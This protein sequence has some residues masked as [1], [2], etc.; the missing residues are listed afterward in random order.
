MIVWLAPPD[1][2]NNKL[3]LQPKFGQ[4]LLLYSGFGMLSRMLLHTN[5][6]TMRCRRGKWW[7]QSLGR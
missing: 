6:P 5:S 2:G 4:I 7:S 1:Y 3:E